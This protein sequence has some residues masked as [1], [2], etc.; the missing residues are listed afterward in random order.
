[1]GR[2]GKYHVFVISLGQ[3]SDAGYTF[4]GDHKHMILTHPAHQ[5][6]CATRCP[7]SS[8]YL[9][10]LTN[11]HSSLLPLTIPSMPTLQACSTRFNKGTNYLANNAF[12]MAT[13]PDLAMYY[14]CA[15]F[16]PVPTTFI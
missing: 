11:P 3:L 6:L 14:H 9:M 2:V 12:A 7:S 5:S 4:Q 10:S 15:A 16:S 1:M 8:M 13:K